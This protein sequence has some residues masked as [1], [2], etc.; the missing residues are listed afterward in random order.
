MRWQTMQTD[1]NTKKNP[2]KLNEHQKF[3]KRRRVLLKNYFKCLSSM[4]KGEK[5]GGKTK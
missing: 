3:Q 2:D 1:R 4:K 5:N